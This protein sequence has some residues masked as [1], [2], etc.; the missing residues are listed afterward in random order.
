MSIEPERL[1]GDIEN[2]AM[3]VKQITTWY[4]RDKT[5]GVWFTRLTPGQRNPSPVRTLRVQVRKNTTVEFHLTER[6]EIVAR[7]QRGFSEVIL[8]ELDEHTLAGIYDALVDIKNPPVH[9][10][11]I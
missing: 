11:S 3:A 6:G 4:G 2:A 1:V 10:P 8:E 9:Y 7:V 5:R